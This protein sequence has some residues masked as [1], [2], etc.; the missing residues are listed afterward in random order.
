[1]ANSSVVVD[2]NAL[3]RA[4]LKELTKIH[5]DINVNTNDDKKLDSK[6][7]YISPNHKKFCKTGDVNFLTQPIVSHT[8]WSVIPFKSLIFKNVYALDDKPK[9]TTKID[10][11]NPMHHSFIEFNNYNGRFLVNHSV[12]NTIMYDNNWLTEQLQYVYK[13][14]TYDTFTLKGYTYNGDVF[15]NNYLRGTLNVKKFVTC[16]DEYTEQITQYFPLFMQ[17]NKLLTHTHASMF[18]VHDLH[19]KKVHRIT[20]IHSNVLKSVATIKEW[21]DVLEANKLKISERYSIIVPLWS[22]LTDS[23]REDA[24][25]LFIN[26]LFSIIKN[27]PKNSKQMVV[28]RGVRNQFFMQKSERD[29]YRNVGFVSTSLDIDIAKE[30]Q[31]PVSQHDDVKCCIQRVLLP[32]GTIS[33][34]LFPLSNFQDEKEVLLPTGVLY[35]LQNKKVLKSFYRYQEDASTDLCFNNIVRINVSDIIVSNPQDNIII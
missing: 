22:Y 18:S 5:D 9:Y 10:I 19:K 29:I 3:P 11:T 20:K 24:L 33:I 4:I 31:K 34:V 21:L 13:L 28:Y 26:D 17:V 32:K 27:A 23:F 25:K 15:A 7:E 2:K 6:D 35:K 16:N 14:S 30:F 8:T 1:M 12:F